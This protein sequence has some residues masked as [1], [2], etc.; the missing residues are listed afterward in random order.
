[1]TFKDEFR[2]FQEIAKEMAAVR[3]HNLSFRQYDPSMLLMAG[4]ALVLLAFERYLRMILGTKA[5][6]KDTLPNLLEKA[7]AKRLDL[8]RL[9][10][11][12]SRKETIDLITKIWKALTHANYEQAAKDA[13]L[14]QKDDYFKSGA[15]LQQ[16]EMVY[17]V[18]NRLSKQIDNE[19]GQP[20]DRKRPEVKE[21][22]AS[23]DFVDLSKPA[24]DEGGPAMPPG[25]K[26]RTY[27]FV[28]SPAVA[29]ALPH[30]E[31]AMLSCFHFEMKVRLLA[32]KFYPGESVTTDIGDKGK[33]VQGGKAAKPGLLSMLFQRPK[34]PFTADEK[35]FLPKCNTLRNKLI[36][37]EPDGV[38]KLVQELLP[39]FQPPN[40]VTS[41][42]FGVGA[43][44]AAILDALKT[45]KGAVP[46]AATPSRQDG[47][48]G[49]MLQ[50][51]GDGTFDLAAG[52]FKHGIGI[53]T[54]KA[55]VLDG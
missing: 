13:G 51:A 26:D 22:L 48:F 39:A 41:L 40:K 43:S 12:L 50:A 49:W 37:C 27:M 29:F 46:V 30:W 28:D 55:S 24:A 3:H 19:T 9:P 23:P 1:M 4:G 20:H 47:F 52:I 16:V 54:A 31:E 6:A 25:M 10:G 38:R 15:Y 11:G 32:G 17:R 8:V 7:T 34:L 5:S 42:K 2:E 35:T 21:F 18:L 36:H 44:G 45:Q 14:K 53:I 33:A